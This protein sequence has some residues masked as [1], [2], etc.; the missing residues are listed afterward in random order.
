MPYPNGG[1]PK[2]FTYGPSNIDEILATTVSSYM[3]K[4]ADNI[5]IRIPTLNFLIKKGKKHSELISGVSLVVPIKYKKNSTAMFY[6]GDDV[7]DITTQNN[8]TA[9]QYLWKQAAAAVTLNG[10]EA[11]MNRGKQA[12]INLV[13][14]RLLDAE[15][16]GQQMLAAA[17]FNTNP[18]ADDL[19][20]IS[21]L[22]DA[23]S[24]IGDIASASNPWWQ[25]N[26]ISS[27]SF[28]AEGV[29]DM[30]NLYNTL[31]Q[32]GT[33]TATTEGDLPDVVVTT[34]Q[35]HQ[36][37]EGTLVPQERF[38]STDQGDAG[39]GKLLFKAT[40]IVWDPADTNTGVLYMLNTNHIELVV[41]EGKEWF[42]SKW[43][44]SQTQDKKVC[45]LVWI[46]CLYCNARR[47]N[48]KLTGIT[49]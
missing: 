15:E 44:E 12:L 31:S 38:T 39:F 27:G 16:S 20:P 42:P 6:S 26:V 25:A 13:N 1:V 22:V 37:Y 40:P 33:E 19:L 34:Q 17:L 10:L 14:E 32:Y 3:K 23:S 30:R 5:Y 48:G 43:I 35:I 11:T 46:G 21:Q 28:S 29:A 8:Y 7:L 24:S 47:N 2:T 9:A 4:M 41:G 36:F 49:A 18:G 45:R